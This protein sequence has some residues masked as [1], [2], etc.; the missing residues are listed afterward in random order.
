MAVVAKL[1]GLLAVT[2]DQALHHGP[3]LRSTRAQAFG[4]GG[5]GL[6]WRDHKSDQDAG[7]LSRDGEH[8]DHDFI[9]VGFFSR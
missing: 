9:H 4:R 7:G 3:S 1:P 6:F 2:E 8:H 5:G